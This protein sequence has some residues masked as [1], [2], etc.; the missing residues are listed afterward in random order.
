MKDLKLLLQFYYL[1]KLSK[2]GIS[3]V[4]G[5]SPSSVFRVIERAELAG[6][7]WPLPEGM[8]DAELGSALYPAAA[9][10]AAIQRPAPD[11]ERVH[12]K[13]TRSRTKTLKE[14]WRSYIANDPTG[15]QYSRYCELYRQWRMCEVDPVMR[16]TYK[17]GEHLFVDY[18]GKRPSLT[19]ASTGEARAVELLVATLGASRYT[20]AEATRT[21]TTADFCGSVRRTFEFFGGSPRILVC[22]NL[23]AAV[24]K[25]RRDDA[26]VLNPSF[27]DLAKHYGVQVSPV[28]PRKLQDKAPVEQAVQ[29][30]QRRVLPALEDL[31]IFRSLMPQL[32]NVSQSSMRI[33]SRV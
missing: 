4:L 1:D 29:H 17:A 28:R 32:P 24:I 2:R 30:V 12:L 10:R 19:D 5:I 31:T 14:I 6:I 22:D 27:H 18:S 20:Y 13:L 21:Q 7:T 33:S 8:T 11:W 26:A 15:Y 16:Q 23:K 25:F 9:R 3:R